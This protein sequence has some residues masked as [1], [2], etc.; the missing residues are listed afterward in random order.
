MMTC[1]FSPCGFPG[2]VYQ[3]KVTNLAVAAGHIRV[4][5]TSTAPASFAG[6]LCACASEECD[7]FGNEH[8]INMVNGR[9]EYIKTSYKSVPFLVSPLLCL[10]CKCPIVRSHEICFISLY[11]SD[12]YY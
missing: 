4:S 8:H 1:Q 3:W 5:I 7:T 11:Y 12:R 10:F 6:Q 2:H 9:Y